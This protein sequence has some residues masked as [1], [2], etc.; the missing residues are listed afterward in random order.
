M[1]NESS[2]SAEVV[3]GRTLGIVAVVASP[4]LSV[5]AIV[6]GVLARSISK[7]AGFKNTPAT[8]GIV[9]GLIVLAAQVAFL[10]VSTVGAIALSGVAPAVR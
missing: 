1:F 4:F 10:V 5:P 6:L 8:V 3:P 7:R 2:V 9:I